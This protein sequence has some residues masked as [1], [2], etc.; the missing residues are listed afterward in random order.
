MAAAGL[1]SGRLYKGE[2]RLV[3]FESV[4]VHEHTHTHTHKHALAHTYTHIDTYKHAH[5][6]T[7][8]MLCMH[9]CIHMYVYVKEVVV[10][11]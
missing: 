2:K 7:T 1:R 4:R 3:F 9:A 6:H 11:G 8:H 5:T 10:M